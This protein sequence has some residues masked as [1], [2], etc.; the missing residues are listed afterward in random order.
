MRAVEQQV[1]END[2]VLETQV[3]AKPQIVSVQVPVY[4]GIVEDDRVGQIETDQIDVAA[5]DAAD[6]ADSGRRD[7]ILTSR[8]AFD[9]IAGKVPRV[10]FVAAD[11][12]PIGVGQLQ[13]HLL[14]FGKAGPDTVGFTVKVR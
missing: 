2:G 13:R 1:S 6:D 9:D 7:R 10:V 12:I 4:E 5:K 14:A 11:L 8:D 3:P